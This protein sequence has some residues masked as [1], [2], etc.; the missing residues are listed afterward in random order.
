MNI[1]FDKVFKK[2]ATKLSPN[3]KNAVSQLVIEV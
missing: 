1:D 2:D 3:I